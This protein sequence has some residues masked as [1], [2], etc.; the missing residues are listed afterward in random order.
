MQILIQE[1]PTYVW[2]DTHGN[3]NFIKSC[4]DD[5]QMSDCNIIQV[6]D[7]GM[8][9]K[10][11]QNE[12]LQELNEVLM[13]YWILILINFKLKKYKTMKNLFLFVL[14]LVLGI[15]SCKKDEPVE[16]IEEN[17]DCP[18][19][20]RAWADM[21]IGEYFRSLF[22]GSP[23]VGYDDLCE[24]KKKVS[25]VN[26][27]YHC[28]KTDWDFLA[29]QDSMVMDAMMTKYPHLLTSDC[30][31]SSDEIGVVNAYRNGIYQRTY[32][33]L[34]HDNMYGWVL[35]KDNPCVFKELVDD[36]YMI[37]SYVTL[38][39]DCAPK[40]MSSTDYTALKEAE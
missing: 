33:G 8:G 25:Y 5:K 38:E 23:R 7:F 16:P 27:V 22:G 34:T 36:L 21:Y 28:E 4:I 13:R 20:E 32:H 10:K 3:W 6:G 40:S 39:G 35:A 30:T 9:Y 17:C 2:G 26:T 14:M 29:Y 18:A 15:T 1:L 12:I 19:G 24:A 37:P 11:D 31:C